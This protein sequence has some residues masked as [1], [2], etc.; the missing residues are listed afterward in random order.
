VR[1][2]LIQKISET[3]KL[4]SFDYNNFLENELSRDWGYRCVVCLWK[5][6]S[7]NVLLKPANSHD[8]TTI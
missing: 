5:I 6:I 8:G 7:G 3:A 2:F 4:N 1:L